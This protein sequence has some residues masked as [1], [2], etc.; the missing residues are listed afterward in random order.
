MFRKI[1]QFLLKKQARRVLKK[2]NPIIIGIT[3]SV[4]KSST[5]EMIALGLSGFFKVRKSFSNYNNEVGVPL[6]ILGEE[7]K[8]NNIAKWIYV[9][10]K[11]RIKRIN[12][13]N[14]PEVLVLEMAA[15]HPKDID[16]LLSIVRPQVG[17]LT[18]I[19][20]CHLKYFG[21]VEKVKREKIK[22]LTGLDTNGWAIFN[23]DN[24][25]L[26]DIN[27]SL[28]SKTLTYGFSERAEVRALEFQLEY[29]FKGKTPRILGLRFKASCSGKVI[30]IFLPNVI[31]Q[32]L[33]YS[34]LAALAVGMTQNLNLLRI[35][36]RLKKYKPLPGRMNLIYN[37]KG[38]LIIDDIYNSSPYA[39]KNALN[40]LDRIKIN[41]QKYLVLGDMLELGDKEKEYH[42]EVGQEIAKRKE[43]SLIGVG[44]LARFFVQGAEQAGIKKDN[45]YFKDK[46]QALAYLVQNL[47]Q[48]D[49]VLVKGSR[50]TKMEDIVQGLVQSKR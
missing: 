15:D 44:D 19:A 45:L 14:Y 42:L 6:T 41:G 16:Y 36:E 48:G 47:K 35:A 18:A 11:N 40:D 28:K 24:P 50:A 5:K 49:I 12:K 1:L 7:S 2:I 27:F 31:S 4:G 26:R 21:S 3:G 37:S 17:V 13:E 46:K 8:G 32:S 22:L 34:A 33:V 25:Y 23:I 29:S 39:V 30:P 38:I 20:P 9:L 10:G 43:Y